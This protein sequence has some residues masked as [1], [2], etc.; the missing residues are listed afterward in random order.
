MKTI[1]S[2]SDARFKFF[3]ALLASAAVL[4]FS[5]GF[6][7]CGYNIEPPPP[8]SMPQSSEA[9]LPTRAAL[10]NVVIQDGQPDEIDQKSNEIMTALKQ[11][12]VFKEVER[13]GQG[14]VLGAS[15]IVRTS[16]LDKTDQNP[17]S[18]IIPPCIVP[19]IDFCIL[20]LGQA[21]N[22]ISA[23]VHLEVD[24][25]QG[26]MLKS[27]SET[28]KGQCSYWPFPG[29][30]PFNLFLIPT[31]VHCTTDAGPDAAF[32]MAM[33]Q[34]AKDLI[35]DRDDLADLMRQSPTPPAPA[36]A[37]GQVPA[38]NQAPAGSPA[39][40]APAQKPWWQQQ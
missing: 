19:F 25:T 31:V 15:L 39:P 37:T 35:G 32:Q 9:P 24:N 30:F 40:A 27:Y 2:Q 7:G 12:G 3:S 16:Y 6:S 4:F 21:S 23:E 20:P 34:I 29:L 14:N 36:A 13:A 11:T 18:F 38:D 10:L 5:L 28:S 8:V 26:M 17:I 22:D 33:A 1:T